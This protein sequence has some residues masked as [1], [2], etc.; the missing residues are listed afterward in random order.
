MCT[1]NLDYHVSEI[2]SCAAF[3]AGD[4]DRS[5]VNVQFSNCNMVSTWSW[6]NVSSQSGSSSWHGERKFHQISI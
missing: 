5:S 6:S 2:P 1:A 3:G 4:V